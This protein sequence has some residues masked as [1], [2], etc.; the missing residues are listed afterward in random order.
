MT[1]PIECKLE[2]SSS[3]SEE[4]KIQKMDYVPYCAHPEKRHASD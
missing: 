2:E 3:C 1:D 4:K